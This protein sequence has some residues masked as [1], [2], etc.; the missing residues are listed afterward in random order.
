MAIEVLITKGVIEGVTI[1][2]VALTEDQIQEQVERWQANQTTYDKKA[3][4]REKEAFAFK[5]IQEL[6][7]GGKNLSFPI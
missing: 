1:Y 3:I 2:P 4:I 7:R 6:I 5:R